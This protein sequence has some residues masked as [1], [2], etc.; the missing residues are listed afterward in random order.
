MSPLLISIVA[1]VGVA[2]LVGGVAI[3]FRD[4]AESRVEDRLAVLTG[5]AGR[6]AREEPRPLR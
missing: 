2:A 6:Q 5:G 3:A 4:S 1:F